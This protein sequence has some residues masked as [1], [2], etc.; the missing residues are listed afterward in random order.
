MGTILASTLI[1]QANELAQDPDQATWTPDQGLAWLNDAQQVV[2]LLRPDAS[3]SRG[4]MKLA[5]G[6]TQ[7]ITGRRLMTV[8]WN[9]GSDGLTRGKAIRLV[10]RGVMDD[11]NPDWPAAVSGTEIYEYMYDGRIPKQFDVS[12]PVPAAP[13]IWIEFTQAVNPAIIADPGD[14]IVLDDVYAPVMVS[15][16]AY[17]YFSRDSEE[18]PNWARAAGFYRDVF[19]MLDVKLRFDIA[20]DP[21]IRA[22]LQK[23]A[24]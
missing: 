12:P 10:E 3:V 24:A 5:Q 15:W 4:T 6:V 11:A 20:M 13:D 22:H 19:N 14:P 9:M 7:T 16:M 23:G 21:R 2:A 17:R 1:G 18:T 8:H